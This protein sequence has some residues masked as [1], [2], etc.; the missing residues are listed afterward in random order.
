MSAE[1]AYQSEKTTDIIERETIYHAANPAHAKRL[2][3]KKFLKHLVPDWDTIK[4]GVMLQVLRA[5]FQGEL[6]K[7]LLETGVEELIESNW[8]GDTYWGVCNGYG[9]NMLGKLLMQVR[10]EIQ[11]SQLG[12]PLID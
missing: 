8:W 2:G 1:H 4:Q 10:K 7:Q 3:G 5:K 9:K 12:K 11:E 6:S